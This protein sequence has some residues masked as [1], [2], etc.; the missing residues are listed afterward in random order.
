MTTMCSTAARPRGARPVVVKQ[1]ATSRARTIRTTAGRAA[2]TGTPLCILRKPR[3]TSGRKSRAMLLH[4]RTR[5]PKA[6][7]VQ[8]RPQRENLARC[9]CT[10]EPAP[11]KPRACKHDLS[12][13]IS[14]DAPARPNPLPESPGRASTT[15]ARESRAMLLHGRTRSPKAQ[16]VQARP[17]RENLARCSCTAEPA[18]P[19]AGTCKHDL[20]ERIWRDAPARPNPLPESPGRASTTSARESGAVLLHGRARYPEGRDV[21]ARPQLEN[22][23]RCSCT[24]EPAPRKPRACKHDLS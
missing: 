23:A 24:A 18:T 3:A 17:Q 9:S 4:G 2:R 16:G 12:E 20:S 8:A 5:S 10:A 6:Q 19:K 21:Q 15:S 11:R 7:G 14:R 13:R 1:L 22:L